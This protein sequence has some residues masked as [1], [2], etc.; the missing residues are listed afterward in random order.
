MTAS[1]FIVFLLS[2]IEISDS[3]KLK[4]YTIVC[5]EDLLVPLK[6]DLR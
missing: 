3:V 6:Y 1:L 2:L 4:E 5:Y